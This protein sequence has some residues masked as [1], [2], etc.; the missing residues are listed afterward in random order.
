MHPL[1]LAREAIYDRGAIQKEV[2]LARFVALA[3]CAEPKVTVE[4]GA[5]SGGTLWAW[6]QFCPR[7]IGVD[8]PPKGLDVGPQLNSD[9]CEI[10]LGHS[11]DP[12]TRAELEKLLDGE[13]VDMLFIDADHTFEGVKADF[14]LYSPLVRGGGIVAFHDICG[15]PTMRNIEVDRFWASLGGDKEELI[16]APENWGGIGVLRVPED[17]VIVDPH[18]RHTTTNLRNAARI[19]WRDGAPVDRKVLVVSDDA[20]TAYIASAAFDA[21]NRT[22][23]GVLPYS[24]KKQLGR[25]EVEILPAAEALRLN[26]LDPL[27]P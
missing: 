4:V 18:A 13:P 20:Q 14:E 25:F 15:H 27:D 22:E 16:S 24:D 3:R 23:T 17:A 26:P 11:Q 19:L 5:F 8:R 9:G 7:V 6:Q 1:A 21:R 12:A 10:V 2:E